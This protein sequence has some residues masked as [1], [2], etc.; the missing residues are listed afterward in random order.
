MSLE[1]K[2]L[3]IS[4]YFDIL[5][6]KL[7]IPDELAILILALLERYFRSKSY[8]ELQKYYDFMNP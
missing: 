2:D 3:P 5:C 6:Q 1:E 4:L 7:N 8:S